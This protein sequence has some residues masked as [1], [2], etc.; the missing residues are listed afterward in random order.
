M[1]MATR[2]KKMSGES[3]RTGIQSRNS[4]IQRRGMRHLAVSMAMTA[5]LGVI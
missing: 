5:K 3:S 2:S 1:A 4:G